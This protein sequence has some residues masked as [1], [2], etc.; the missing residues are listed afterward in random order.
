VVLRIILSEPDPLPSWSAIDRPISSDLVRVECLRTIERAR[1]SVRIAEAD[2]AEQ[3]R[4]ALEMIATLTLVPLT[5]AVLQRA[6]DPFPTLISTFD[7]IHLATAIEVRDR[8]DGLR[9]ATHDAELGLAA[10]SMGFEV[11]GLTE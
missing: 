11:D 3:R 5:P 6:A 9:L 4:A 2:A 10:R 7:A 8:F 1:L